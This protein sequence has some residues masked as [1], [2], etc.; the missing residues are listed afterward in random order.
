M[1]TPRNR[2]YIDGRSGQTAQTP[3]GEEGGMPMRKWFVSKEG[4]RITWIILALCATLAALIAAFFSFNK[5]QYEITLEH[6]M[7]QVEELSRYVEKNMQLEIERY[8][9]ILQ[10]LETQLEYTDTMT[11]EELAGLLRTVRDCS[12]FRMIG[13]SDLNGKGIDS[14][15]GRYDLSGYKHIRED[16]EKGQV[17]ISNVLKNGR[18]TLIFVAIPLKAEE[19]ISGI[20]WGKYSLRKLVSNIEF[21]NDAYRYFQIIDDRGNYLFSSANKHVIGRDDRVTSGTIWQEMEKYT[22]KD[23]MSPQKIRQ[24]VQRRERGAFYFENDGQGRY[25]SFR[26]MR[27]NNWY[28]FSV[29]VEDELHTYVHRTWQTAFD[30]FTILALGMLVVFG[31]IY[32]MSYTM[33]KKMAKQNREIQ[34]VNVMFQSTLQQTKNIPFV[35]DQKLKQVVFYGYPT[36]DAIRCCSFAIMRPENLVKKGYLDE[37]SMEE[38]R[39]MFRSLVTE[40]KK[41]DPVIIYILMGERKEWIRV[42]ITADTQD[43]ADQMFGVMEDYGEQKGKD[44][45]IENHLDDIKK[46]EKKAQ[47]DFLTEL[48]NR[49]TFMEKVQLALEENERERQTGALIIMDLDHFKEVND[50]MGHGMGDMV[51]KDTADTLRSFFRKED[52]V[53]RLGGDEFVVFAKN[54]RNVEAFEKRIC[55]LNRLLCETYQKEE[56]SAQVSASIGIML[57]DAEHTTFDTLYEKADLALYKVKQAGRN[58]YCVY[59]EKDM[60]ARR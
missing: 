57:T 15:G 51:L 16:I 46:I 27:I 38:Y 14:T 24:M 6:S 11:P 22:Y 29:Q 37:G 50:C 1:Y 9:H 55:E 21:G 2:L 17:Y 10:V 53:G 54:V 60:A 31:A 33:Y 13:V 47:T 25:V 45:Q 48:Y 19:D 12:G 18:E 35:I 4:K 28:L 36:K 41:C 20:V 8:I 7:Q 42:S 49:E 5:K 32:N 56:H 52:I 39:K 43:S 44:L 3:D 58:G 30:L 59:S 23:G 26:P 34:A 40:K